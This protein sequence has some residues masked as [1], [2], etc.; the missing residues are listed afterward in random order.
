MQALRTIW[1]EETPSFYG[2]W[3]RL[4]PSWVYPKPVR[5]TIPISMGNAGPVGMKLAAEVA[6]EWCPI[7]TQ[8]PLKDAKPDLA[9]A[10]ATFRATAESAG[11][12]PDRIP[13]SLYA[14]TKP[15]TER[16]QR[17]EAL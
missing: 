3:D 14:F 7:D 16:M 11:R 17:Y 13:I 5:G 15:T 2:T 1:A 9:G 6:D 4:T 12:D 8:R 10:V